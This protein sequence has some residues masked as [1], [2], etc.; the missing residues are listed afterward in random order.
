MKFIDILEDNSSEFTPET[1]KTNDHQYV[2]K[3]KTVHEK[4]SGKEFPQIKNKKPV[5]EKI[6]DERQQDTVYEE[7]SSQTSNR[8]S[9]LKLINETVLLTI[10]NVIRE[11]NERNFQIPKQE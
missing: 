1:E 11:E 5:H 9:I 7:S 6:E 2:K 8:E 10:K 3:S 4:L